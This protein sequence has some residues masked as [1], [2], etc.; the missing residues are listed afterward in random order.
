MSLK[1][2]KG[3]LINLEMKVNKLSVE[4]F[5]DTGATASRISEKTAERLDVN[6]EEDHTRLLQVN[7]Y[8]YPLGVCHLD[9]TIANETKNCKFF[10]IKGFTK[11][12]LLGLDICTR[13]GMV[14]DLKKN[15]VTI[16]EK[17]NKI[18]TWQEFTDTTLLTDKEGKHFNRLLTKYVDVFSTNEGDIGCMKN[19]KHEIVTIDHP[20]IKK[21]A[22]AMNQEKN[23]EIDRQVRY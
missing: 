7:S 11:S 14:I 4:A 19:T 17:E 23:E 2:R 8:T 15:K 18:Y 16:D 12:A 3:K 9:I 10:V 20:P 21:R 22:Y 13:F 1:S 6:I 5:I